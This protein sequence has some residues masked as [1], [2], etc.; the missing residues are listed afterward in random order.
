MLMACVLWLS[1]NKTNEVKMFVFS[2]QL[3]SGHKKSFVIE[4][5]PRTRHEL[6]NDICYFIRIDMLLNNDV[7]FFAKIKLMN[8]H[9]H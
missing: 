2:R 3:L 4:S 9:F 5:T 6:F 1:G 7:Y 8:M